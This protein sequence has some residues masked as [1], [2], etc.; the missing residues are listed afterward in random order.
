MRP[1]EP[2]GEARGM[3]TLADLA[4][5][6]FTRRRAVLLDAIDQRRITSR[7]ADERIAPW[8]ALARYYG[9]DLP[10]SLCAADG[11]QLHWIDFYPATMRAD[12]AMTKMATEVRRAALALLTRHAGDTTNQ[13]TTNRAR[14]LRRVDDHLSVMAKLGPIDLMAAAESVAA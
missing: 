10:K 14:D 12:A 4:A 1:I 11:S 9:A 6:E 13:A 7:Q 2:K 5:D 8:A 3:S